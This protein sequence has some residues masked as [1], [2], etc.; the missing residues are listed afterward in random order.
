MER[1]EF[2]R[3]RIDEINTNAFAGLGHQHTCSFRIV[4]GVIFENHAVEGDVLPVA[5]QDRVHIVRIC[6]DFRLD[7]NIL[8]IRLG[9]RVG[10]LGI[11]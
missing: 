6:V 1:G 3:P 11:N 5:L 9:H 2:I 8:P 7:Q 4:N 10:I